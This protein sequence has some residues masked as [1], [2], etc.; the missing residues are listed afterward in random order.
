MLMAWLCINKHNINSL[1]LVTPWSSLFKVM[2]VSW[3]HDY[4]IKWK[5]FPCYWPFVW[6]IHR[7]PVNSPLKGQWC[8]ALMFSLICTWIN[9]WVNNREA[10]DL[11]RHRAH[12][13]AI[14]MKCRLNVYWTARNKPKSSFTK[15]QTWSCNGNTNILCQQNAFKNVSVPFCLGLDMLTQ[16]IWDPFN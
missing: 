11:R 8:R 3:I 4:V 7:S 13:D 10:C 5:H 14:V 12:Y 16:N 15:I 1:W 6:G 9:V 2:F